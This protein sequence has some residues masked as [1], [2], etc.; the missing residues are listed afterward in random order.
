MRLGYSSTQTG[1]ISVPLTLPLEPLRILTG[2][3]VVSPDMFW[4]HL[5]PR[6]P[7]IRGPSNRLKA[8]NASKS[9]ESTTRDSPLFALAR[10]SRTLSTQTGAFGT[11]VD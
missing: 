4:F 7:V 2:S 1:T 11:S 8:D 9:G 6:S 5:P 3:F 10:C